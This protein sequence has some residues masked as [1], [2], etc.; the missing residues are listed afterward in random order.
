MLQSALSTSC[1]GL[2]VRMQHGAP[3]MRRVFTFFGLV[4][5]ASVC[6]LLVL[7]LTDLQLLRI[8]F[9]GFCALSVYLLEKF[10]SISVQR[11]CMI[12]ATVVIGF[13]CVWGALNHPRLYVIAVYML[14]A[15]AAVW[16]MSG[17]LAKDADQ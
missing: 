4:A 3:S 17:A 9:I 11:L 13:F 8:A 14:L 10:T 16:E 6:L 5:I 1:W 12:F 15:V 7:S 2:D